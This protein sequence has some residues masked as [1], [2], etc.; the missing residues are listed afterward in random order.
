MTLKIETQGNQ[1]F[2]VPNTIEGH[3]FL[4]LMNKFINR[5]LWAYRARGRG[6]RP[7]WGALSIPQEHAEW[8]AVYIG[9][10]ESR[11]FNMVVPMSHWDA[12]VL[13]SLRKGYCRLT[14][15]E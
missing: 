6:P 10:H 2:N 12:N 14:D 8:L 15:A 9:H 5:P 11:R 13:Y 7:L 1:V 3:E 4:R